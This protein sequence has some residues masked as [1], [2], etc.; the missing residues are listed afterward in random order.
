MN[1]I[2]AI[3]E[4]KFKPRAKPFPIVAIGASAG[5]LSAITELLNN[6]RS[7]TGMAYVYIQHLDPDHKSSLVP[8]LKRATKMNVQEIEN[9]MLIEADHL[10]IIPPDKDVSIIDGAFKLSNRAPRSVKHSP[11]DLFF[12]SLAKKQKEGAIGIILSGTASDGALGLKAIKIAGG[13]TYVQDDSAEFQSMPKSAVAENAVDAV[14]SPKELA[15]ELE[16]LSEQ[17]TLLRRI[18]SSETNEDGSANTEE[19]DE[20]D[21]HSGGEN[22]KREEM[23]AIVKLVK[24][25]TGADFSNY[26]K[27]TINRRIMR[28]ILLNKFEKVDEYIEYLQNNPDEINLLYQDILINVTSFF[29]DVESMEFLK[30]EVLPSILKNK[31][32]NNPLR[33]WVPACSTG[34]EVY[35]IA[36]T[37]LDIAGNNA[38]I[39]R[40]HIFGTDLS[41]S[42]IAKARTGIYTTADLAQ[43]SQ[44]HLDRFFV[45]IDGHYRI[46]KRVRDLCVFAPHNVFR[47]P[48]FSRVDIVSCCNLLI[49]I[50]PTLQKKI[51]ANF[52]YALNKNGYLILGKSETIG[53]STDLFSPLDKKVRIYLKKSDVYSKAMFDIDYHRPGYPRPERK[54][55]EK[56]V[57]QK[58]I[59]TDADLLTIVDDILL[60][61]YTPAAVVINYHLDIIQFRGSTSL[62][63]EPSPG[64]ASFNLLKMA[65]AG[66]ELE[67]RNAVQKVIKTGEPIKKTDLTVSLKGVLHHITFAVTPI[68]AE[69]NDKLLLIVFEE[70]KTPSSSELKVTFSKDKR[71]K[72]L[73]AE[74]TALREDMR[75]IVEEQ[76]AANEE[77]QAANEEIVS[78]NEEL[79]SINEELETSK[80]ELESGN[81]ELMTINQELQVRNE[82]IEEAHDYTEALLATIRE[83]AVVLDNN[84]RVKSANKSFYRTF[85]A[86]EEETEGKLIYEFNN[87]QWDIPAL[88]QFLEDIIPRNTQFNGFEVTHKFEGIGKKV[89]LL[90]GRKVTQKTN[91][92]QFILLAIEDITEHRQAEKLLEEREAWLRKMSDNVPVMIWVAGADKNFNYLNKTWLAYTGRNLFKETGI[93]WTEGVHK[94]DLEHVLSTYHASFAHHNPFTIEY[95]MKR[96]DGEYRW[97]LNSAVPTYDADGGFGGYTGS[98]IEIHDQRVMSEE[99]EKIVSERTLELQEVNKSL[100]RSNNDL[101]QFAYVAS[102]DLQEPLRKIITFSNRLQDKYAESLPEGGKEF[103]VKINNSAGRM[104]NLIDDLLNFSRTS[105]LDEKFVTTDLNEILKDVLSDFDLLIQEKKAVL[106]IGRLPVIEAV[107]LHINQLFHNLLSNALKF[108]S[109]GTDPVIVISCRSLPQ[110]EIK[111][112]RDLDASVPYYEITFSDNGMGFPQEFADQIFVIFQRLGDKEGYPGTGIGLAL[113]RKIASNHNG[114]IYAESQENKGSVFYVILPAIQ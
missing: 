84:L 94:N 96:Y 87:R 78:S 112:R 83:A 56:P 17:K 77:L 46:I 42:A 65:R 106:H 100:E 26:K 23:N 52:H 86:R 114:E 9:M 95:R 66:L 33:I 113:C 4:E 73:E 103:I 41:E 14:M 39:A 21:T 89:L 35:S 25:S 13:L 31:S 10:F 34:E 110:E 102:H 3:E 37:I 79:Q 88:K 19:G 59:N 47:D 32:L 28:R 27:N 40:I 20:E 98:C 104:R 48:P 24:S 61:Q 29:R 30:K 97:I 49:Y 22:L 36:M 50:E 62:F 18:L 85:F 64:R 2:R 75:L 45:K 53:A 63:L 99:L 69:T 82:Q 38:H 76:E 58:E 7:E 92:Q 101:A 8:I 60:S 57:I 11:I 16:R 68:L 12:L 91:L 67:L 80:E 90:N 81:E 74:V 44:E 107:P 72:H 71:V 43:L 108:N 6:L 51:I 109:P 1:E 54:A 93:G 111:K 5:G 70:V 55:E 15:S 105:R